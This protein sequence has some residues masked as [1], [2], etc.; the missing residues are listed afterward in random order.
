M[1]ARALSNELVENAYTRWAPFYDAAFEW[2]MGY[3]RVELTNA[4]NRL[5]GRVL[6][7]GIGTGLELPLF[8]ATLRITGVDLSEAM[9]DIARRRAASLGLT[10]V[11]ALEVM[12]ALDLKFDDGSFDAVVAPYVL[13]VVPSPQ[14]LLDELARVARPGGEIVLVNHIG[15]AHGPI[16]WGEAALGLL[17]HWLGW[18]P[19]FPWST[20]TEWLDRRPDIELLERRAVAPVGLFTLIRM[21]KVA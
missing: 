13:T 9:L 16:A 15:A 14:R 6:D 19:Q 8:K 11:D 17:A 2:V 1:A 12:D 21:R 4:V 20:V 18:N 7:V 5:D 10:N 3:G